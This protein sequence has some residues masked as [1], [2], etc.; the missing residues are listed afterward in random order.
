MLGVDSGVGE[1]LQSDASV[2]VPGSAFGGAAAAFAGAVVGARGVA[3][4][5]LN[6]ALV[7]V[8]EE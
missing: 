3:L 5:T 2:E 7:D 1:L 8:D 6:V 4:L